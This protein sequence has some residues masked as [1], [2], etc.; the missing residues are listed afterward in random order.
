MAVLSC[1]LSDARARMGMPSPTTK[2]IASSAT[3]C[4]ATQ[5]PPRAASRAA[6]LSR[7][8]RSV[9]RRTRR[10]ASLR[11]RGLFAHTGYTTPSKCPGRR[12][13]RRRDV[14]PAASSE[15]EIRAHAKAA[16]ARIPSSRRV[17]EAIALT[18]VGGRASFLPLGVSETPTHLGTHPRI[19]PDSPS[20]SPRTPRHSSFLVDRPA[21]PADA[22]AVR[23]AR[24]RAP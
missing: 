15:A 2:G 18:R 9:R 22:R 17:S 10:R 14:A 8:S 19:R 11:S 4:G 6:A 3:F 16:F 5:E 13:F 12:T 23:H 24:A 21:M 1:A 20:T 7:A